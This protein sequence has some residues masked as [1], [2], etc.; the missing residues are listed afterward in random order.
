MEIL[1]PSLY[2]PFATG[3]AE[4]VGEGLGRRAG[5]ACSLR[6]A[7]AVDGPSRDFRDRAHATRF[8]SRL[9]ERD[10]SALVA[11]TGE[12]RRGEESARAV[13]ALYVTLAKTH[14]ATLLVI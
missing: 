8:S 7:F 3:V 5:F 2:L 6:G 10:R 11:R 12:P 4:G 13:A 9:G 1:S 14:T